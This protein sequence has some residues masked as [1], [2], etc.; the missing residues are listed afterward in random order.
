MVALFTREDAQA[1][2]G[3]DLMV[4]RDVGKEDKLFR[5]LLFGFAGQI[6]GR[7]VDLQWHLTHEEFEGAA[8]QFRAHWLIW[9]TTILILGVAIVAVRNVRESGQHRGYLIVLIAN[10]AYA[11][12]AAI[13]FFQHLDHLEVDWAHL[14]LAITSIAAAIGVLWVIAARIASRRGHK[15][16]V[17]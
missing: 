15:E 9:L 12:V 17:A 7:L 16:A 10:V 3:G 11:V 2:K 14:L 4:I 5:F 6:A 1:T 8:E 13:H